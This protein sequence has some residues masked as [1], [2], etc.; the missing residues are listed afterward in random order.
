MLPLDQGSPTNTRP[1][2]FL[3]SVRVA[4]LG[5][6]H[7]VRQEKPIRRNLLALLGLLPLVVVLPVSRLEH[8]VLVLS[9]MLVVLVEFINSAIECTVDRISDETHAL[10]KAAK[11][12]A[13]AAVLVAVLMSGLCWTVIAGP[14]LFKLLFN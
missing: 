5:L 8:L 14:V 11:D 10:S 7:G 2:S 3:S 12:L 6:V 13:S 4:V 1:R 9:M